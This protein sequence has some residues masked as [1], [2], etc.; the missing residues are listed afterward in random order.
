MAPRKRSGL[1][2]GLDILET[3]ADSAVPMTLT[4]IAQAVEMSKSSVHTLLSTLDQRG[5]VR[6]LEDQRYTIG[7]QAWQI[8]CVA[9]PI[10]MSRVAGPH[11][12]ELVNKV[13]DGAAMAVLDGNET[14]CIQLVESTRAVRVHDNIGNRCP[15]WCVSNG[16]SMLAAMSDEN[17]LRLLPEE[18]PGHASNSF[19]NS[20]QVMEKLHQVRAAGHSV[21][22]RAWRE[23]TSGISLPVRG[24]GDRVVA[25]LCVALPTFHATDER[26]AEILGH[27]TETVAAIEEDFGA[28]RRIPALAAA[29]GQELA[30]L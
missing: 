12:T 25:A 23:D 10:E 16:I 14:V 28:P 29:R 13:G 20:R 2:S 15:A 22:H 8:G 19:S 18:F 6:R 4:A 3:L 21:M 9:A 26:L 30:G 27:L 24:P 5:Y 11:M 7:L 1:N 17:V